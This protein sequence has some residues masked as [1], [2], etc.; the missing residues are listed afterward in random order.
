M[1]KLLLVLKYFMK[2]KKLCHII[3]I[4]ID[5][6]NNFKIFCFIYVNCNI[7]Y[8]RHIISNKVIL[9]Y[10]YTYLYSSASAQI[11]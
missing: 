9:L 4:F 5:K 8:I 11:Y 10:K 1:V 6:K 3:P 7:T 2:F